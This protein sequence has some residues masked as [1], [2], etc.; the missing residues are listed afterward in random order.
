MKWE[1]I[2]REIL[3][4]FGFSEEEDRESAKLLNKIISKKKINVARVYT[5]LKNKIND[6]EVNVFG[7][8]PALE[9]LEIPRG[10]NIVANGVTTFFLEKNVIPDVIVTDLDGRIADILKASKEG[11]IVVIHAHGDNIDKIEKYAKKFE[12][13]L[14]T[15]QVKPF[16]KLYNFGGF[17]DGDRA[18]FL[19]WH[20]KARKINLY[21]MDFNDEIGKYS[22]SENSQKKRKKLYWGKRLIEYLKK[23]GV[24][25][26]VNC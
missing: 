24:P 5:K 25:I 14:G 18:V 6:K 2:Y 26:V 7:A 13:F 16:G 1:R 19:A 21:A 11:S 17:T 9:R 4:D 12:N 15:T 23:E 10:I 3:K 8:S 20:F 22:F